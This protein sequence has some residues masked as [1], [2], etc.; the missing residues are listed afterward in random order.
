MASSE[1]ALQALR[2]RRVVRM[3]DLDK[4]NR[5]QIAEVDAHEGLDN[6]DGVSPS[7]NAADAKDACPVSTGA[8]HTTFPGA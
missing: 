8:P 1:E 5:H 4:V 6:T 7:G 3:L 2:Q